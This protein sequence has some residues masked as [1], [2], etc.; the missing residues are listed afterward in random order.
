MIE[1]QKE[2]ESQLGAYVEAYMAK[3]RA[4]SGE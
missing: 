3:K 4:F 2:F 1:N